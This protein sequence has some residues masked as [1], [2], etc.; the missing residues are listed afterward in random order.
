MP[1]VT[2]WFIKSGMLCLLAGLLGLAFVA[3]RP[4]VG[5]PAWL[6][7]LW[8]TLLHLLV[9]GWLTQLIFGVAHW[10]FPRYTAEAPR[11]SERVMWVAWGCLNAGLLLR[12]VGEPRAILGGDAAALLLASATLQFIAAIAFVINTWPRTKAR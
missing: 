6:G 10:M 8:P 3:A 4:V 2:R 11:G 5:G 9:I 7:A 12:V 1:P